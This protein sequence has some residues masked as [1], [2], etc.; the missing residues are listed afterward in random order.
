MNC[1]NRIVLENSVWL[2]SDTRNICKEQLFFVCAN[3]KLDSTLSA[4]STIARTLIF[5][6]CKGR[7]LGATEINVS[8]ISDQHGSRNPLLAQNIAQGQGCS[9]GLIDVHLMRFI[10]TICPSEFRPG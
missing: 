7:F 1:G 10:G 8:Q 5:Q 9:A 6:P 2:R 4:S 3:N